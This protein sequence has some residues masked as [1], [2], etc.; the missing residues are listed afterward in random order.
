VGGGEGARVAAG[1]GKVGATAEGAVGGGGEEH[2]HVTARRRAPGL[3]EAEV[4]RGHARLHGEVELAHPPARAPLAQQPPEATFRDRLLH[5]ADASI[6]A[7]G[8]TLRR[9]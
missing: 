5:G 2:D 7:S 1:G 8:G 9:G 4:A 3:D 6:S